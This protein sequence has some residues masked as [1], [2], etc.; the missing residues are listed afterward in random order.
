VSIEEILREVDAATPTGRV[1]T[2][3]EVAELILFLASRRVF[4]LTGAEIVLDG[5]AGH[6]V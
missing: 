5:G 2:P 1:T 6:A 3:D 4:N